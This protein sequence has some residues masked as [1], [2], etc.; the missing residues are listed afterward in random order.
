MPSAPAPDADRSLAH[1]LAELDRI[2]AALSQEKNLERLLEHILL[3]AQQITRAE[4]G[5]LYRL[6]PE[7]RDELRFEI[8]RNEK[9]GI[10]MGGTTGVNV[11]FPPLALRDAAG[12]PNLSTVAAYAALKGRT[13]AIADAYTEA[14]FDFSGT[15]AIDLKNGYRSQSF[16]TV[17]MK[18][19]EADVIGVLQLINARDPG[20]GGIR[21][22]DADDIRLAES[23]ASQAATVLTNRLLLLQLEGLFESFI[24]LLNQAI[25]EKSPYTA[26]HCQRVP[27]LTMM[28]AEA[29][30]RTRTGPLAEWSMTDADRY[31]LRIAGLLHDCGKVA[32]PV[33]VVDK[34]T[35]LQTIFDRIELVDTRF[36]LLKRDAEL[37]HLRTRDASHPDPDAPLRARLAEIEDDRNFLRTCNR[38]TELMRATDQLRVRAIAKKYR[39]ASPAGETCDCLSEDEIANLT[40]PAG[41]LTPKERQIINHHVTITIK[42]LESL[43]WP[44]HLQHVPEYAGGHHERMDGRGYPRGLT[45]DQLSI[46]ARIMGIADIFEALTARD[47][48]YKEGKTLSEALHILGR[49]RLD[50]GIDPDLF[51]IFVR[52]RV[53]LAYAAHHMDPKQID[54]VDVAKIPGYSGD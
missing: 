48:P 37:A 38:G 45:R 5:T 51:D 32:T 12:Q 41:T 19:H 54:P 6:R 53:Y 44:K 36:E 49:L 28:L 14:G 22:F 8:I 29:A 9:L 34:A 7:A 26:G 21:A 43:P 30:H 47:R 50:G 13:V 18:N 25:D 2:G 31:E 24:G 3:A 52:E 16:L 15:K 33:H 23:L 1:R 20:T 17:P 42:M 27:I 35:K 46:P 11:P 39:W 40:I 4:G 10:A